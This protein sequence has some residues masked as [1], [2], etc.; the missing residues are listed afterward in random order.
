MNYWQESSNNWTENSIR[1][2]STP[3][4]VAKETLCYIQEIGYFE[5]ISPYFTERANLDSY[6]IVFTLKGKGHLTYKNKNFVLNPNDLFFIDCRYYQ[7]YWAD[8]E[9]GWTFLW[10][11]IDGGMIASYFNRYDKEGPICRIQGRESLTTLFKGLLEL[12]K[13]Q[14]SSLQE[15][16]AS[17]FIV[18]ILTECLLCR[19]PLIT[20]KQTLPNYIQSM[21]EFMES[22]FNSNLKLD[23]LSKKFAI[24]KYQLSRE[25]KRFIG[26]SP[27]DYLI[28]RRVSHAKNQLRYT[29]LSV[30]EIAEEVGIE[31]VS[32]FIN[33]F[34]KREG[35]TPLKYR[36]RW[37]NK[38][39]DK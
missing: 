15:I 32:H 2:I 16:L 20:E 10:M 24:N 31:N 1:L 11:H 8:R 4:D 33:L 25:F 14:K 9:K 6:L 35:M 23:L 30:R 22:N 28:N 27:N 18:E 13:Q 36:N 39:S 34:K 26:F 7:K 21:Q 3:S 38:V 12:Q 19:L 29:D 5:T 37:R 17:K